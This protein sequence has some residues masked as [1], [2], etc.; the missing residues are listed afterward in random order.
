MLVSAQKHCQMWFGRFQNLPQTIQNPVRSDPKPDKNDQHEPEKCRKR[1]RSSQER[2]EGAQERKMCQHSAN[3]VPTCGGFGSDLGDFGPPSKLM[4][5]LKRKKCL[6]DLTR[7]ALQRSAADLG[8]LWDGFWKGFGR[9]KTSIL[10]GFS[11]KNRRQKLLISWKA[12][13]SHQVEE[14]SS[15]QRV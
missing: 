15:H 5:K 6:W 10:A 4:Q 9:P 2:K 14:K 11:N 7:L 8:S 13:R 3:M 12:S 1:S